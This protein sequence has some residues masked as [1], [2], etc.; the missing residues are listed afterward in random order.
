[1][2]PFFLSSQLV[3]V[4]LLGD[5]MRSSEICEVNKDKILLAPVIIP[6]DI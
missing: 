5:S 4:I 2:Y 6:Y 1:M 3:V